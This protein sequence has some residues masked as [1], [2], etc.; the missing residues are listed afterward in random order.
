MD[1][2]IDKSISMIIVMPTPIV[3]T[4]IPISMVRP[5]L[6]N[7]PSDMMSMP[8]PG[9][10]LVNGSGMAC[11]RCLKGC[12]RRSWGEFITVRFYCSQDG[13]SVCEGRADGRR[14]IDSGWRS[15]LDHTHKHVLLRPT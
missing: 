6:L 14:E 8:Q 13:R 5:S 2:P 12:R 3:P 1:M 7:S 15:G 11:T 4:I 9:G 10:K